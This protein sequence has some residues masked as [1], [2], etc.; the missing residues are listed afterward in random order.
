MT[1]AW[2]QF[3]QTVQSPCVVNVN[4]MTMFCADVMES[5]IHATV[6]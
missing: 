4:V 6:M 1:N 2:K 5:V 3:V